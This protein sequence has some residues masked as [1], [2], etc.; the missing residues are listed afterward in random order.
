MM[1]SLMTIIALALLAVTPA[2]GEGSDSLQVL[3]QR[4]DSCMQQY[5][6]FEALGYY[7][8]AFEMGDTLETR[9]KLADC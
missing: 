1:K 6:T 5:N 3:L 8:Q 9:T 7:R 2:R 4:G